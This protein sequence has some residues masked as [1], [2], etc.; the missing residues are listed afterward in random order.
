MLQE[1]I[2]QN[3]Q[4]LSD[5]SKMSYKSAMNALKMRKVFKEKSI[6]NMKSEENIKNNKTKLKSKKLS[7]Q[8]SCTSRAHIKA[9]FEVANKSISKKKSRKG[10]KKLTEK[11]SATLI[12]QAYG[13]ENRPPKNIFKNDIS[14]VKRSSVP[15]NEKPKLISKKSLMIS[16]KNH[17]RKANNSKVNIKTTT[18]ICDTTSNSS[19]LGFSN[20]RSRFN[21]KKIIS[22]Q[23]CTTVDEE[24]KVSK[25]IEA[26]YYLI[27]N[28]KFLS[29]IDSN[30]LHWIDSKTVQKISNEGLDAHNMGE[31]EIQTSRF[32]HTDSKH[33]LIPEEHYKRKHLRSSQYDTSKNKG[34]LLKVKSKLKKI[35]KDYKKSKHIQSQVAHLLKVVNEQLKFSRSISIPKLKRNPD[36]I[37]SN[38]LYSNTAEKEYDNYLPNPDTFRKLDTDRGYESQ[39]IAN[40]TMPNLGLKNENSA[41]SKVKKMSIIEENKFKLPLHLL[42]NSNQ[43]MI[44]SSAAGTNRSNRSNI[45]FWGNQ[46]NRTGEHQS[47]YNTADFTHEERFEKEDTIKRSEIRYN[48]LTDVVQHSDGNNIKPDKKT[49]EI[50]NYYNRSMNS[51][52]SQENMKENKMLKDALYATIKLVLDQNK[53][54]KKLKEVVT[55]RKVNKEKKIEDFAA[56]ITDESIPDLSLLSLGKDWSNP[57]DTVNNFLK[58]HMPTEK[59]SSSIMNNNI[60]SNQFNCNKNFSKLKDR[61]EP[62]DH[63]PEA[64]QEEPNE[65]DSIDEVLL[66][67][68]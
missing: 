29:D 66:I 54:I 2:N 46:S 47:S 48:K 36:L 10:L 25:E 17:S 24:K 31:E 21:T 18:Q 65:M 40:L 59:S 11:Q 1:S 19:M 13:K 37:S 42:K 44:H 27:I 22:R 63:I 57:I 60:F 12:S 58:E 20:S 53:Q 8:P 15:R 64:E 41:K 28:W 39:G 51:E 43:Q 32:E 62:E 26:L 7:N 49:I 9:P 30:S 55:H 61:Q 16:K 4:N 56:T 45:V 35:K 38:I 34:I 52:Q 6:I 14:D 33:N 5:L 50:L 3:S 68:I 23:Y 67:T